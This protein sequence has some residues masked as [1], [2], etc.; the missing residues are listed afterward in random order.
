MASDQTLRAIITVLDRT[1]EPLHQINQRFT[2]LGAPLR[3]IG[4][5]VNELAEET[6]LKGIGEHAREA[7]EHVRRLGEG[8]LEIAGPLAALGAAGSV[9]GLVEIAKSTA[10][11]AEKLD[12]SAAKTGIA[13]EQ[14][15]GWHYAA[16]LVGVDVDQL[17]KGFTYLNRNINEAAAGK[18]KDVETIL[19]R[20]GFTN[21]PGHLVNTSDALKAIAAEVKHLVDSG[22]IQLATDMM[23][24]LFGARQ[25]AQLL[26][27]FEKGPEELNKTLQEAAESGI[28]LTSAQ[29]AGG[30]AFM[31]QYKAMAAAVE[32]LKIAIGDELFPVLTP[33]IEAMKSF[34]NENRVEIAHAIGE[35]VKTL[36]DRVRQVDWGGIVESLRQIGSGAA[37]VVEKVGGIGPA[38]AIIA[39]ISLAPTIAAFVDLGGAVAA[40]AG[41]FLLFPMGEL[42]AS[43]VSIIPEI[44]SLRDVWAALN[45]VLDA[46]PVG[47]VVLGVTALG[48]AAYEVYHHWDGIADFFKGVW[49]KVTAIFDGAWGKIK[50][51]VDGLEHAFSWLGSHSMPSIGGGG[52]VDPSTGVLVP[53][54]GATGFG[55]QP[56]L[57]ARPGAAAAAGAAPQGQTKMTVDFQNMPPGAT[58]T[59][60]TRGDA[61]PPQV[62]VGYAFMPG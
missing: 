29:T 57:S 61:E 47:A 44:T 49:D 18:A 33:A 52:F 60:E 53:G 4:S 25:G 22:Q 30:H 37:W 34:L 59:T 23:S 51:V 40:A 36:A 41:K 62:A 45:L 46:N 2:A 28:S 56:P 43:V 20:M 6:G 42:L 3:E 21:T 13:T 27:L 12:I 32:G 11:F 31:E 38:I 16:G 10:E 54:A 50:P 14:L 35:A 39:G 24:K 48:A 5:R 55:Q 26:P 58:V 17:D 1:A 15:A 9:A 19:R 7:F 8:L